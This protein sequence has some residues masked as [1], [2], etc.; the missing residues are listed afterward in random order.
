MKKTGVVKWTSINGNKCFRFSERHEFE[1]PR[2]II[3][4][5][6]LFLATVGIEYLLNGSYY[7]FIPAVIA[8]FF[9]FLWWMT[10]PLKANE[11]VIEKTVHDLMDAVVTKDAMVVGTK[12]RRSYVFYDTKGTYA[13]ITGRYFL[14]LLE[15]GEVWEYP[16]TYHHATGET[17]G[18]YECGTEHK[19]SDNP[20]HIRAIK[21]QRWKQVISK[22]SISVKAKLWL[23]IFGIIAIGGLAFAG[24][25]W[26]II[27]LKWRA[28]LVVGAYVAI[29]TSVGWI[30]K[31]KPRKVI[32]AVKYVVDIP[33]YLGSLV[34]S[35]IQPFITI[36]GTYFFIAMFAFGVPAIIL[37]GVSK[38]GWWTL[39]PEAIAF[40]VFALGAVLCSTYAITKWIIRHTPLKDWGNHTYEGHREQ[41]AFYLAHPSNMVFMLYLIYFVLL[42]LS[43]Y[44]LIQNGQY[45]ISESFDLAILKAFLVFIAYTNMRVKAKDTEIDAKELLVRISRLFEHDKYE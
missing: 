6:F 45:L 8:F 30:T 11:A 24:V 1:R 14:V 4:I 3:L 32:I 13:I 37:V 2:I 12:V 17:E 34:V 40:I 33:I 20:E 27:E 18:Y 36:V 10:I 29:E 26:L 41:L 44:M 5:A 16:L 15:N 43:G 21:P 9:L 28:L 7:S 38:V 23:L 22:L 39:K 19:V 31:A 35:S 25:F 42:V